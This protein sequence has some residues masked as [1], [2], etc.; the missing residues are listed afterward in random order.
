MYL[1]PNRRR[2]PAQLAAVIVA[3][4][5]AVSPAIAADAHDQLP[6][7]TGQAIGVADGDTLDVRLESGMLRVRLHG[8]DAPERDQPWGKAAKQA[9]SDLVYRKNVEIEPVT[10][11]QY[12]RMVARVWLGERS[13]DAE[14]VAGG[15]AWVYRRY[16]SEASYC[17]DEYEAREARRG[18]WSLPTEQWIAPWEWRHRE[19]SRK[20][21]TDYS[22][23]T[24]AE[25]V[26]SLG[27]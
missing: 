26:K 4:P 5:L 9:L 14:L 23:Q 24:V 8:V 16:A 2:G 19:R 18:L 20:P 3:A 10:Q 7:L 25:C 21:F 15:N 12:E 11:D 17:S 27:R 22:A 6:R 13:V 1:P